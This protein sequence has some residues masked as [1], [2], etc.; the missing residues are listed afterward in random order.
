MINKL[1]IILTIFLLAVITGCAS[2]KCQKY[3]ENGWRLEKRGKLESALEQC[4]SCL[5]QK[6][7]DAKA[8]EV[9]VRIFLKFVFN[10]YGY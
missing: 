2:I 4:E 3:L 1:F 6:H 9:I 10:I 5:K 8:L 7:K